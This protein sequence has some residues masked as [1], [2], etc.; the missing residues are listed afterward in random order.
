MVN[1]SSNMNKPHWLLNSNEYPFAYVLFFLKHQS[2]GWMT[3]NG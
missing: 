3:F 2:F 1:G